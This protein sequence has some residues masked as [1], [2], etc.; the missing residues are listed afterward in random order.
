MP[1]AEYMKMV[2]L[3]ARR[4]GGSFGVPVDQWVAIIE[5][6]DGQCVYCSRRSGRLSI[7][8]LVPIS[9]GGPDRAE[10]VLPACP[11]CIHCKGKRL[12]TEWPAAKALL[13]P[14]V[15]E[16]LARRSAALKV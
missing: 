13:L 7:S 2:V 3:R 1:A 14:S 4:L 16:A 10:N 15:L 6:T 11:R 8:Y 9:R 5:S 12:I